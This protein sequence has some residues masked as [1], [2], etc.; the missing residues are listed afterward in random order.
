[1]E[2]GPL[3]HGHEEMLQRA[4][5]GRRRNAQPAKLGEPGCTYRGVGGS[6]GRGG[7]AVYSP[8][9]RRPWAASEC[10]RT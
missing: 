10:F 2:G 6:R 8:V 4:A 7:P 1:M 3:P 5:E 9:V